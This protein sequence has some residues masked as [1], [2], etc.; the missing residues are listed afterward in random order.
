MR[1]LERLP[2]HDCHDC[3]GEMIMSKVNNKEKPFEKKVTYQHLNAINT[4]LP[5]DQSIN[6]TANVADRNLHA[7]TPREIQA[8]V[9]VYPF[10]VK[11]SPH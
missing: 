10:Y 3:H 11:R 2:A 4:S 8:N 6:H 1:T 5:K 7:L 9:S